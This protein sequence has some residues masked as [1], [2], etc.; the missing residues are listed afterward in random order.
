VFRV[1]VGEEAARTQASQLPTIFHG[2]TNVST[3]PP[4]IRGATAADLALWGSESAAGQP[5]DWPAAVFWGPHSR[6]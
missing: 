2:S 4:T 3:D 6:G 5:T 1:W